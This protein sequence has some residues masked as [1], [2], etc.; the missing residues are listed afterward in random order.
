MRFKSFNA[1]K[2]KKARRLGQPRGGHGSGL[3]ALV[4]REKISDLLAL[5]GFHLPR[6]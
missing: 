1:T 5:A 4:L 2:R 6:S 3:K